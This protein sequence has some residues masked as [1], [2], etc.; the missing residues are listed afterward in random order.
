MIKKVGNLKKLTGLKQRKLSEHFKLKVSDFKENITVWRW[1]M[2]KFLCVVSKSGAYEAWCVYKSLQKKEEK[3]TF[4]YKT[5]IKMKDPYDIEKKKKYIY[6]KKREKKENQKENLIMWKK[7]MPLS[8]KL[9]SSK[10]T[11]KYIL[12]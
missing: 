10:S 11:T 7:Y 1:K 9:S 3:E 2:R 4:W 6:I 8:R 5:E 12:L